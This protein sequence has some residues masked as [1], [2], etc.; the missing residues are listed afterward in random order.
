MDKALKQRLV[1]ASVLI[2]LAVIVLPM[3]LSGRPENASQQSQKIELPPRPDELTFETR[4]FPVTEPPANSQP[5]QEKDSGPAGKTLA[6]ASVSPGEGN[7]RKASELPADKTR[8]ASQDQP[9]RAAVQSA[10]EGTSPRNPAANG[11]PAINSSGAAS[12]PTGQDK[13]KIGRYVVQ[14]ASLGSAKNASQ[15]MASLQNKGLP[16]LLDAVESDAGK[17]NRIRVGPYE[18]ETEANQVS[19]RIAKELTGV[20]PRVVDLQ[21]DQSSDAANPADSLERWVVQVGSFA[22][23]S[24]AKRIVS[25]LKAKGMSAYSETVTSSSSTIF[26]VRVGPFLEREE[27][28]RAKQQLSKQLSIDGVVMSAD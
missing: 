2:A 3:L 13:Q 4:R 14:V 26:R 12:E 18:N 28:M 5:V 23:S 22:D 7:E 6:P 24:N 1:G 9:E 19:A 27:A 17:L 16:V 10:Q 11:L 21:P 25:E 8:Q 15:L 20:N